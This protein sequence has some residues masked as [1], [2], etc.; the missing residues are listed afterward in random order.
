MLFSKFLIGCSGIIVI[1]KKII[2]CWFEL[3]KVIYLMLHQLPK[4]QIMK[5][6]IQISAAIMLVALVSTV[7]TSCKKETAT[8]EI[9][10]ITSVPYEAPLPAPDP[11]ATSGLGSHGG[12]PTGAAYQLPPDVKLIGEIR[13]GLMGGKSFMIPSKDQNGPAILKIGSDDYT[14]Y[15]TGMYVDLY[16]TFQNTGS[17]GINMCIPGGL[18]FTDTSHYHQNGVLLQSVFI[19]IEAGQT[20]NIHLKTYCCNHNLS[21]SSYNAVYNIGP[22]TNYSYLQDVINI[23]KNKQYPSLDNVYQI[24]SIIWHVTDYGPMTEDQRNFLNSLP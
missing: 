4:P 23:M 3:K 22:V 12:N 16:A 13:G 24:Q 21:P 18:L 10:S 20:V 14:T 1:N 5:K 11:S 17:T 9:T 2:K 15:G 19:T 7:F 6:I 8:P